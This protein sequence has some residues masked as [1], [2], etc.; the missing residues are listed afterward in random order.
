MTP[1]PIHESGGSTR[2]SSAV[3]W[4]LWLLAVLA[5]A[6]CATGALVLGPVLMT[7][8]IANQRNGCLSRLSE[9]Q[10]AISLYAVSCDDTLPKA[11]NWM[12]AITPYTKSFRWR[13]ALEG[14]NDRFIHCPAVGR[15]GFGYA[16]NRKLSRVKRSAI[17]EPAKA[18]L[19]FDSAGTGRNEAEDP[20]QLPSPP[21]H[22]GRNCISFADGHAA[23]FVPGTEP[24]DG[25]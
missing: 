6:V 22:G 15:P 8:R 20:P 16:M 23:S 21:R 11:S 17:S 7:T 14:R 2:N 24:W 10:Q 19:T 3:P 4:V 5:C 1:P 18:P 12:D 25:R 9:Q 13:S